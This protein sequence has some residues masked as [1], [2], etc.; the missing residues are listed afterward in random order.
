MVEKASFTT[1]MIGLGLGLYLMASSKTQQSET[2]TKEEKAYLIDGISP[3][4]VLI[5]FANA[6]A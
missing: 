5:E 6:L 3:E 4:K 2:P 1:A